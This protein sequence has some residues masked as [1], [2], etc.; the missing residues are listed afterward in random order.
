MNSLEKVELSRRAARALQPLIFSSEIKEIRYYF[1]TL[2]SVS[3][4][5]SELPDWAKSLIEFGES[6]IVSDLPSVRI[7]KTL[8]PMEDCYRYWK[9]VFNDGSVGALFRMNDSNKKFEM[10]TYISDWKNGI[11]WYESVVTE[12]D[13]PVIGNFEGRDLELRITHG[14]GRKK[15]IN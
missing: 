6:Q 1:A 2:V 13:Y 5:F 14:F 9:R 7:P 3:N 12:P 11:D 8:L 10:L 15:S 4:N